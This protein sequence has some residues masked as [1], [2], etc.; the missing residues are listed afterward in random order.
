MSG[1]TALPKIEPKAATPM[2]K[3]RQ[4]TVV[5]YSAL[6]SS[7]WDDFVRREPSASFFHLS[8]WMRVMERTFGFRSCAIYSE[9]NGKITGVLPLFSIKN[10]IA[11]HSLMST[12]FAVYGGVAAADQESYSALLTYAK[13]QARKQNVDYLELR[14]RAGELE[15]G[16][17]LKTRY[18]T[19]TCELSR[20]PEENLK[21]L[22]KDTRYMIRKG[23]KSGL[24][25]RRGIESLSE[26]C[27]LQAISLRRLGTPVFPKELLTNLVREFAGQIELFMVYS[28]D[29][30][31]A[32][33][34]TFLF[35]DTVLPF[36][37][38]AA[39]E[40]QPLAANNFLY[41]ELMKW[42]GEQ[43]YRHFDFGRS[44]RETG[45]YFFKSQWNMTL[46]PLPYQIFLV[47]KKALPDFSPANPAFE[48]ATKIWGHLPL[49]LTKQVG[50]RVVRW[51][52]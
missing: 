20:N 51:F 8:G 31:V 18:V 16:F 11:G 45:A 50:P 9:R 7:R 49:W 10:W 37:S 21:R 17:H 1:T 34:L 3:A 44:K 46:N 39:P 32:G 28:G 47:N 15:P 35:N 19:F 5:A 24:I 14:N 48:K 43:G 12:P 30:A 42:A 41:W 23:Q 33:V 2:E 29:K 38:G 40:A 6:Q 27:E 52:P 22:P 25:I 26:F 4:A 36:Y 13:D